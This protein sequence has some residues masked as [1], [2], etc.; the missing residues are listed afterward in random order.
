MEQHHSNLEKRLNVSSGS[1]DEIFEG[2]DQIDVDGA[3]RV[4]ENVIRANANAPTI[5]SVSSDEHGDNSSVSGD[6]SSSSSD[7]YGSSDDDSSSSDHQG[8]STSSESESET[9][10]PM[11]T[12]LKANPPDW[13]TDF[14]PIDVPGFRLQSGPDLPD[15]WDIHS[16]PLKYFQLFFTPDL[17][18]QF[19]KYTNEYAQIAIRKKRQTV[20]SYT[21][22][23]WPLDGSKNVTA[24]E[25]CAYLGCCII[26]SVNPAE[27]LKHAFSSDPYM[28]NHGIRSI[29][30]LRRFTKIGQYLCIYDKQNELPR[31]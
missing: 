4:F 6:D 14:T 18:E 20:P 13:T 26:L 16:P 29:F 10:E 30:T 22:K 5:D 23:Q 17:I 9:N 27:Q 12:D 28:S 8:D 7:D 15:G 2:F 21:D 3:S 11:F 1:E 31:N 25:L 19:V 24:E